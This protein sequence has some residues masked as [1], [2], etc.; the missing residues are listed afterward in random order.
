VNVHGT[1][2]YLCLKIGVL[3]LDLTV[4]LYAATK[5]AERLS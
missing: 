4:W 2:P 1:F 5:V 3:L